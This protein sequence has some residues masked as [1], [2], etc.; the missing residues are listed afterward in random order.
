MA[1]PSVLSPAKLSTLKRLAASGRL[2]DAELAA[3]VG[4]SLSTVRRA[5][6]R[7]ARPAKP[8][9]ASSPPAARPRAEP[10]PERTLRLVM[11]ADDDDDDEGD[12]I[13]WAAPPLEVARGLLR[14]ATGDLQ[15]LEPD[16]PRINPLRTEAR[17]LAR[18]ISSLEAEAA[19]KETPEEA[20]LRQRREARETQQKIERYVDQA[21]GAALR[22]TPEAPCG[23][24]PTCAAVLTAEGRARLLGEPAP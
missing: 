11:P 13:D 24:C 21:L 15:K 3:K 9:K 7:G 5:L 23:R 2:T 4:V 14:R 16:S 19:A 12:G 10:A 8:R 22:A 1:P 18:L 17:N 6:G 20:E